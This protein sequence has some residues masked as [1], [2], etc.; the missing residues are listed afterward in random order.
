MH[1]PAQ[2]PSS[3]NN[4][5][6]NGTADGRARKA[7]IFFRRWYAWVIA[8]L[9][10][11]AVCVGIALACDYVGHLNRLALERFPQLPV[12][13]LPPGFVFLA[14]LVQRFFRGTQGSGIP[15]AIAALEDTDP[16]K[17]HHLLSLRILCGKALLLVGGLSMGASIGRE[18]PT[19]Q[20]GASLMHAFYGRGSEMTAENRK[21]LIMAGGAA[22]IAAAFNTPLAGVMFAI[23]ELGKKAG[24]RGFSRTLL[25]VILS[26]LV[27]LA[28]VGNYTYFG[29]T[30]AVMDG[31]SDMP[32]MIVLGMLGGLAGGIFSWLMVKM[33]RNPPALL[34]QVIFN[35][36]LVFAGY[37]GALLAILA[38][39]TDN[40]V[41]GTGYEATRATLASDHGLY[42]WYYGLAKMAAT[43]LSS[44]SGIPG[45]LFAPSLSVGAGLGDCLSQLWPSLAPHGAIVLLVMAAYLAGVTQS[46]LTAIVITMEMSNG[47]HLLLP[48]MIVAW[49]ASCMS[50]LICREPLYDA[51]SQ[52]FLPAEQRTS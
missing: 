8:P 31:L 6:E 3:K 24:F 43:L 26:A 37:C 16:K 17:K 12:L 49:V 7:V 28:L 1:T 13:L 42:S 14:Y 34:A 52:K 22:G 29:S 45:G 23:E 35:R 2:E 4:N 38:M 44:I 18:G 27:S 41:L 21:M 5:S 25:T 36:P 48:L 33:Q 20:I 19:V 50:K 10:I 9:L 51:L 39:L 47:L 40:L 11:G 15:Q 30:A 46:P 32:V